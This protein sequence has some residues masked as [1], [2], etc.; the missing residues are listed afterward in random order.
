MIW[1]DHKYQYELVGKGFLI[2]EKFNR[3]I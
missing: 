1:L 3:E 2:L